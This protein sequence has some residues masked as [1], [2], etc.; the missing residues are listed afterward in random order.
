MAVEAPS[1]AFANDDLK[2]DLIPWD[3]LLFLLDAAV[4]TLFT[5]AGSGA[6]L[7]RLGRRDAHSAAVDILR[8]RFTLPRVAPLH[9]CECTRRL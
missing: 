2:D 3:G 4:R 5:I 7:G 9:G 6:M 1:A 8:S